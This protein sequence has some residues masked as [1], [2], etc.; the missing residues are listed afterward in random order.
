MRVTGY[1]RRTVNL[2][3]R[4]AHPESGRPNPASRIRAGRWLM[5]SAP[6]KLNGLLLGYLI[7]SKQGEAHEEISL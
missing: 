3:S 2:V 4:I 7:C 5:L 1:E 6:E